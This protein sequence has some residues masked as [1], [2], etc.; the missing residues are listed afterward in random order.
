MEKSHASCPIF[1]TGSQPTTDTIAGGF[2]GS[3]Y[4]P[5]VPVDIGEFAKFQYSDIDM[6]RSNVGIDGIELNQ[7]LLELINPL[8]QGLACIAHGFGKFFLLCV[9]RKK[10]MRRT[11]LFVTVLSNNR[12]QLSENHDNFDNWPTGLSS[13]F[14]ILP[15]QAA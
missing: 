13:R 3:P 1:Q 9:G 4:R 14:P 7:N 6:D 2:L 12:V 11:N 8:V 5:V 15:V 10:T